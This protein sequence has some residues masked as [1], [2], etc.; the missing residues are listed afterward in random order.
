[1]PL[2]VFRG[3]RRPSETWTHHDRVL[4]LALAA[5]EADLCSGCG[6]P[7]TESMDPDNERGYVAPPPHRC[8]ACTAVAERAEE[9]QQVPHAHQVLRFNAEKRA[10]R[11]SGGGTPP[12]PVPT[13]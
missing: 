3:Q 9:Y 13:M 6:Q 1:M 2:S 8:H 5:Y 4:A 10:P 11:A 12:E 7:M